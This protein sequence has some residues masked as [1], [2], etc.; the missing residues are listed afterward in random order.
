M[1]GIKGFTGSPRSRSEIDFGHL[2]TLQQI[3]RNTPMGQKL[4]LGN[5]LGEALLD[6]GFKCLYVPPPTYEGL[7][8]DYI[9]T[10]QNRADVSRVLS[11]DVRR[12]EHF[13]G[14]VVACSELQLPLSESNRRDY[15]TSISLGVVKSM[16]EPQMT[17]SLYV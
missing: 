17:R 9:I 11:T 14:G 15:L 16:L 8:G 2:S 12:V 7:L 13:V 6:E 5:E 4:R 1:G 10:D 3:K